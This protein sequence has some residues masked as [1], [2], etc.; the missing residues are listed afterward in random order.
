VVDDGKLIGIVTVWD[1]LARLGGL[2]KTGRTEP[3]D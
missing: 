2:G 3:G 1:V